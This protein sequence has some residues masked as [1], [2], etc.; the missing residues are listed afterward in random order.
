VVDHPALGDQWHCLSPCGLISA[1]PSAY[2]R[3]STLPSPSPTLPDDGFGPRC[4]PLWLPLAKTMLLLLSAV[5]RHL[6]LGLDMA[7]LARAAAALHRLEPVMK[8]G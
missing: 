1:P 6:P 3:T 5:S 8:S 4:T 7:V 2:T